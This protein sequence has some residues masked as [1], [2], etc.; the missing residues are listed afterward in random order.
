MTI[1]KSKKYLSYLL[2]YSFKQLAVVCEHLDS[3]YYDKYIIKKDKLGNPKLDAAGNEILRKL[4]PTKG[5]LEIIQDKIK[6]RILNNTEYPSYVRGG[7]KKRDNISNAKVH[8]GKKYFFCTDLKN[9]FPSIK[10]KIVYE[11][12]IK[13]GFSFDIAHILTKLTT[14]NNQLPQGTHTSTDISNLV[15]L[16]I[17][18]N[19][20]NFCSDKNI[21]YTR[22]VDD[23]VFSSS[24][25]FKSDTKEL[26]RIIL[27]SGFKLNN[28]K[29][30]YKVGPSEVTGIITSNNKLSL[31]KYHYLKIEKAINNSNKKSLTALL[32]YQNRVLNGKQC[33]VKK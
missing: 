26:V 27:S 18:E 19:I 15:F 9:Y 24:V 12:F 4:T 14:F 11:M 28:K 32:S 6:N 23:L 21:V 33:L 20:A 29:T 7:V 25:D 5:I 10:P 30:Y 3:Y 8:L 17:D 1:V 22:F 2:G 13:N 31:D 16:P